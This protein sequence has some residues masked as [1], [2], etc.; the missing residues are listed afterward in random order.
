MRVLVFGTFDRLHPGHS[1]VLNEAQ[2][3]G[4]LFVVIARDAN[5][6]RIKG[7]RPRQSE[8]ERRAVVQRAVPHATVILGDPDDFLAPVRQIQSDLI[9]LGYDQNLP[10]GVTE[11][12]LQA[13]IERLPPFQPEKYKSS[14]IE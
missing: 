4:D 5:V 7:K 6:Q 2:K 11:S 10:P 3:R 12:D 13:P 14:L 1:F 8:N 9:L